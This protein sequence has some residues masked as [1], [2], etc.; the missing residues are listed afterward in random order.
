MNTTI[1]NLPVGTKLS[2]SGISASFCGS[3]PVNWTI[4]KRAP[5]RPGDNTWI[6]NETGRIVNFHNPSELTDGIT[7]KISRMTDTAYFYRVWCKATV[8]N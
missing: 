6:C 2:L 1:E 4:T 8:I 5:I 3:R 7:H